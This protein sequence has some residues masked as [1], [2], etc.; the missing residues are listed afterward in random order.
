MPASG[1]D[2][3][4]ISPVPARATDKQTTINKYTHFAGRFDGHLNAVV[5][6]HVHLPMEEVQGFTKSH[7]MST[8]SDSHQSDM[9]TPVLF[10]V[11]IVKSL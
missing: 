7:W 1:D 10:D 11:F 3:L 9:L 4:R 2:L 6:Y 8:R 5:Q